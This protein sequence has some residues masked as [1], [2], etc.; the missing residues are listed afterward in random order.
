MIYSLDRWK[1]CRPFICR[2]IS[3][4]MSPVLC[5]RIKWKIRKSMINDH[6]CHAPFQTTPYLLTKETSVFY[7]E[8]KFNVLGWV[9]GGGRGLDL[10]SLRRLG[11][12]QDHLHNN[13]CRD[14][15]RRY[16]MYEI[17][18]Y[19]EREIT[20]VSWQLVAVVMGL[21]T[22]KSGKKTM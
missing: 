14:E 15:R 1:D 4:T 18:L 13:K 2:N 10:G 3:K 19:I 21:K 12:L 16:R 7:L 20:S 8:F 9:G 6:Q 22:I 5:S 11:V 17:D